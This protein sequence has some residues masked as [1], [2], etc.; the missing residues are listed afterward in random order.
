MSRKA[1]RDCAKMRTEKLYMNKIKTRPPRNYLNI[2]II[3]NN[4]VFKKF[5]RFLSIVA[6]QRKS[7]RDFLSL[8]F[9][10]VK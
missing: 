2:L 10:N 5:F 7:G 6:K 1:R 3:T 9:L 4:F 8:T